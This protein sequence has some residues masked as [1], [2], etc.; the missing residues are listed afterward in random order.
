MDYSCRAFL[1]LMFLTDGEPPPSS[2]IMRPALLACR[3]VVRTCETVPTHKRC[4]WCASSESGATSSIKMGEDE[5]VPV[6]THSHADLQM[7]LFGKRV[8]RVDYTQSQK[9]KLENVKHCSIES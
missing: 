7:W 5:D 3:D 8:H 9:F 4:G 6:A 1:E 2:S